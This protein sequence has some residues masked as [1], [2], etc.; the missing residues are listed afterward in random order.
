M[1]FII[2]VLSTFLLSTALFVFWIV[3]GGFNRKFLYTDNVWLASAASVLNII[4]YSFIDMPLWLA[5]PFISGFI[6]IL[7]FTVLFFYRFFRNPHR[8][9]PG[10]QNDIVSGADGRIIYIKE[11]EKDQIPVTVKKLRIADLSEITKTNILKRP[12]YLIGIAMT[13]FD[14]HVNRSPIDGK[15]V[16]VKHTDG[17]AI[18]L[19]TPVSTITNE[20]NTVVIER[21]DG[22]IAG[23]VQIAARGVRRCI[24]MK[25]PGDIVER[26]SII[27]KIRWGSQFDMIIPR[28][29]EIKIREGEQVYAGSTIIA[30]LLD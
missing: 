21:E 9:I 13:L 28:N 7:L 23:V 16:L 10:D 8:I 22:V 17:T 5:T 15:I 25:K 1:E 20:R 29:C 18:G 19:N 6:I 11:L 27:G 30:R 2:I 4:S 24:I 26:G 12:C 3:K 14:V